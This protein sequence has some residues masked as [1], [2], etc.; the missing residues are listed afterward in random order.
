MTGSRNKYL[1]CCREAA[2]RH[3]ICEICL[4]IGAKKCEKELKMSEKVRDRVGVRQ[5]SQIMWLA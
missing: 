3:R 5:I 4:T 1:I 2:R